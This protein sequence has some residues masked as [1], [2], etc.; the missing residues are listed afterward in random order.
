MVTISLRGAESISVLVSQA[1]LEQ[2]CHQQA[3]REPYDGNRQQ[4][5]FVPRFIQKV[6]RNVISDGH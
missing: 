6:E 3:F 4:H 5:H 1:Q 2:S